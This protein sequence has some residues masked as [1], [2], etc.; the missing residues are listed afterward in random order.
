MISVIISQYSTCCF[1]VTT[2]ISFHSHRPHEQEKVAVGS[3]YSFHKITLVEK[4]KK[5]EVHDYEFFEIFLKTILKNQFYNIFK[6]KSLFK[7]LKY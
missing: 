7:N 5:K 6:D 4:Q 1:S 2:T 3:L